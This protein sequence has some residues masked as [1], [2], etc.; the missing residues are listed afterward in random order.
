[1]LSMESVW[2]QNPFSLDIS[3]M[4]DNDSAKDDFID[5]QEDPRKKVDFEKA[6]LDVI[7]SSSFGVSRSQLTLA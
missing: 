4:S 7:M 6:G 2:I 1:M 5:F 3:T